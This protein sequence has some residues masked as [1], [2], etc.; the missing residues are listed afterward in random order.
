MGKTLA[1]ATVDRLLHHAHVCVTQ[2]ESFRLAQATSGKGRC[3][4]QL[5]KPGRTAGHELDPRW[6]P[7][8]RTPGR[9]WETR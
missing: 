4:A 8:V 2:S 1:T 9:Q 3:P 5:S 6:P 7:A